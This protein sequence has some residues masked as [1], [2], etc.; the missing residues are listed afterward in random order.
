[1]N[2]IIQSVNFK[3]SSALESFIREKVSKLFNH[4]DNIIR[5]DVV[6]HKKENGNLENKLCEIRLIIPGYDHFVKVGSE[7]YEKSILQAVDTLQKIL[8]RNKTRLIAK[9]NMNQSLL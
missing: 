1:M 5:A 8:R 2:I 4:C 6:L 3:A 7:V 9:R